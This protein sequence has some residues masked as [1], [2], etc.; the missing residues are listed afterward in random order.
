[1]TAGTGS[2]ISGVNHIQVNVPSD[3]LEAAREFYVGFMGFREFPRPATFTTAGVWLLAGNFELHLGV[4]DGVDRHKTRAHV[5]YEVNDLAAWRKRVEAKG[6][7]IKDQPLIPGY[8]R[9]QFRDPFGNNIEL[10]QRI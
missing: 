2:M 3:G 8:D 9:F 5:A 1:V 7:T 6:W 4:E 10:I